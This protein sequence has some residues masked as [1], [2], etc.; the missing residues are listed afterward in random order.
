MR[1]FCAVGSYLSDRADHIFLS[2]RIRDFWAFG[3]S[4]SEQPDHGFLSNNDR[5]GEEFSHDWFLV[6]KLTR[7][8]DLMYEVSSHPS[9]GFHRRNGIRCPLEIFQI[10]TWFLVSLSFVDF[11]VVNWA[12]LPKQDTIF[13]SILFI[14]SCYLGLFFCVCHIGRTSTSI[15][16]QSRS[17]S[18]L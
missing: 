3:S 4:I 2:S 16:P 9:P 11:F 18:L 15:E 13:W 6:K 8:D 17:L 12:F 5:K 10:M 14:G 1:D 7:G